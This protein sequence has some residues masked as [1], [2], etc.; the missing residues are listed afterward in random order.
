MNCLIVITISSTR[1][2]ELVMTGSQMWVINSRKTDL[3][4]FKRENSL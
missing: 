4:R 1:I 3:E 2:S